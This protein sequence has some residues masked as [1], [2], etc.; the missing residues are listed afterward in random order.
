MDRHRTTMGAA[1]ASFRPSVPS[2]KRSS[3]NRR[4]LFIGCIDDTSATSLVVLD[5]LE[6]QERDVFADV[7]AT[8]LS[9]E[10]ASRISLGIDLPL[11]SLG[12]KK[13]ASRPTVFGYG[14][15]DVIHGLDDDWD[16]AALLTTR[17]STR[18]MDGWRAAMSG[19]ERPNR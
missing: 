17:A 16:A 14:H 8:L 5:I 10:A 13:I 9:K 19:I 1:C 12:L 6:A 7:G 3:T 11:K 18:W 15:G 4:M 2:P